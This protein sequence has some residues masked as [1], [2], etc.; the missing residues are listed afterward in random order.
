METSRYTLVVGWL[1]GWLVG[2]SVGRSVS[3]SVSQL[4]ITS[5]FKRPPQK[6]LDTKLSAVT[7]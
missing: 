1:V 2:R 6:M 7:W 3:Q 5:G 4:V